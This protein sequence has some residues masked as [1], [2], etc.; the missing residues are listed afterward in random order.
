MR[1][2]EAASKLQAVERGR[3]V[4]AQQPLARARAEGAEEEAS[5][6]P[7]APMG[8]STIERALARRKLAEE[9][10]ATVSEEPAYLS[11]RAVAAQQRRQLA[12]A[13]LLQAHHRGRQTRKRMGRQ[14]VANALRDTEPEPEPELEAEAKPSALERAR[15][16][17]RRKSMERT[18]APPAAEQAVP[19]HSSSRAEAARRRQQLAAATL[20][21]AHYRGWRARRELE[22]PKA[23]RVRAPTDTSP[24]LHSSSNDAGTDCPIIGRSCN[25]RHWCVSLSVP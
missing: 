21:Q 24:S 12:A 2:H 14:V 13:T 1:Q 3:A 11:S 9:E 15:Q 16:R 8:L 17:R 6:L 22:H 25:N 23:V 20:V 19:A 5:P 10:R 18:K 7:S 4:R